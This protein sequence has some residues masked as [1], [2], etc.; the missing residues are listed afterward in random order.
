MAGS[1]GKGIVLPHDDSVAGASPFV[2]AFD[3]AK[4]VSLRRKHWGGVGVQVKEQRFTQPFHADL[5]SDYARFSIVLDLA[6]SQP[7]A[8]ESRSRRTPFTESTIHQ[9]NF[10]PAGCSVWACSDDTMFLRSLSLYFKNEDIAYLG[11]SNVNLEWLLVP[12]LMFFDKALFHIA[13]LIAMASESESQIDDL[14][15]ETLTLAFLLRLSGLERACPERRPQGGLAPYQLRQVTE[16]ICEHLV[17]GANLQELASIAGLSRS[18][19]GCAFRESTGMPPHQWLLQRRILKAKEYLL[20]SN[21][22]VAQV[23]LAV[24]FSDQAHFSRTFSRIVGAGPATW[25]RARMC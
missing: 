12:R 10:A 17:E 13:N 9:M 14:Y 5:R 15:V 19:F 7:E 23:A 25:R 24:G 4:I 22:S 18:Y 6:G 21:L 11:D 1:N 16:Y 20:N 2:A 3:G 8:R